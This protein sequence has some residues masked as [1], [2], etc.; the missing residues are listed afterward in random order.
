MEQGLAWGL[1]FPMA[2]ICGATLIFTEAGGMLSRQNPPFDNAEA[3]Y[4]GLSQQIEAAPVTVLPD[5]RVRYKTSTPMAV[6]HGHE[7]DGLPKRT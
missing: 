5:N 1:L 4:V 2:A 6:P 7:E 3:D